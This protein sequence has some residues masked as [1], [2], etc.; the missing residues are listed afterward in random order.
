MSRHEAGEWENTGFERNGKAEVKL[1]WSCKRCGL[2][3]YGGL[4]PPDGPCPAC[5]MRATRDDGQ[6][7]K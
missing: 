5:S 7:K 1:L 2:T 3:V 4:Q 6:N